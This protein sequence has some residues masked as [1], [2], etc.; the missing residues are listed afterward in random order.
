MLERGLYVIPI[1]Y[2]A[3]AE[4]RVRFR[5]SVSAAH[6]RQELD[7]ALGIIEDSVARPLRALGKLLR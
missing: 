5:V 4:D 7:Q 1:D 6:T 2:P 3:V